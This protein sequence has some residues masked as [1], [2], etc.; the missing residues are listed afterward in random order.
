[1][2]RLLSDRERG[3][4]ALAAELAD[5]FATRA[6]EHDRD[7]SFPFENFDRMRAAGYL[8][9]TVPEELGGLGANLVELTLAQERLAQGCAATAL[10]V[11]MHVSPIG[12]LASLWRSNPQTRLEQWLRDCANGEVVNAVL[13]AE[14][15]NPLLRDSKVVATRVEGGYRLNG[16][17]IFGTGSSVMTHFSSMARADDDG[18]LPQILLFRLPRDTE[19]LTILDTWDTLGMRATQSNDVLFEDVFLPDELIFHRYPVGTLDRKM[20]QTVWGWA[21]P[22]FGATYLG[23]AL[24]GVERLKRTIIEPRG[25]QAKPQV[26]ALMAEIEVLVES[27]RAV[28]WRVAHEM[29]TGQL[30]RDLDVQAGM[31]RAVLAKYVAANNAVAVMERVMLIAGGAAYYSRNPL[32]RIYRDVRAATIQPYNNLEG[33]DLFGKTALGV[34]VAP[35]HPA[36]SRSANGVGQVAPV[37]AP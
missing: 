24:G 20:L 8:R 17:K 22:T 25:L 28:I 1:M 34:E 26:Q 9:L 36:P 29:S 10:V 12:Q 13:S 16:R 6:E 11:N 2:E 14:P 4:V 27:A 15:G 5:D 32:S 7:N 30:L 18:A 35:A 21:M 19:G 33:L 3:F 31:A 37:A 23:T